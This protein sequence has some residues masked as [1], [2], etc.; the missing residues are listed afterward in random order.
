MIHH[1]TQLKQQPQVNS[2]VL[3]REISEHFDVD[4]QLINEQSVYVIGNINAKFPTLNL[5]K[6]LNQNSLMS[7]E[8]L[9]M[10]ENVNDNIALEQLNRNPQ[11]HQQLFTALSQPGNRY[12]ARSMDWTLE[13]RYNEQQYS[14][15]IT[16]EELLNQCITALSRSDT[17]SF[18]QVAVIGKAT[19]A[20]EMHV[21][22]IMPISVM[23]FG[24]LLHGDNSNNA[25]FSKLM[26]EITRLD[27]SS[28]CTDGTRALNFA[29]YN[30]PEVYNQSYKLYYGASANGPNPS[31]YQL[32]DVDVETAVSGD[33]IIA[34]VVFKY[35]GI[36]TG[37]LQFWFSRVDVTGEYPF[38]IVPWL[39]FLPNREG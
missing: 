7:S 3:Q 32:I 18:G 10:L 1:N 4:A 6:E 37:A 25:N 38:T 24:Q 27:C 13:N 19:V 17:N 15:Q 21:T 35:Q 9:P 28:G 5:E 16:T 31:G 30:N 23:P 29:L 20:G 34:N 8:A 11:R 12:I 26:D 22:A 2:S 39:Q 33:R 36:N 14:L